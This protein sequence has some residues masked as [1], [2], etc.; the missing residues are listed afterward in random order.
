MNK[1]YYYYILLI[2]KPELLCNPAKNME[3]D[4]QSDT[5]VAMFRR[6]L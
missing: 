6:L 3:N 1:D 5:L 2:H 4:R